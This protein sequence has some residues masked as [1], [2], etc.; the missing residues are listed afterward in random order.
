MANIIYAPI[1]GETI[2]GFVTDTENIVLKTIEHKK[3]TNI[4]DWQYRSQ[5]I[6]I[7]NKTWR[8]IEITIEPDSPRGKL[9]NRPLL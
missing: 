9:N 5:N 3:I 4:G 1:I 2:P 6:D 8:N 7:K